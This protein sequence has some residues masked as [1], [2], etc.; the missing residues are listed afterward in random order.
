LSARV[1]LQKQKKLSKCEKVCE[2]LEVASLVR[3]PMG[4]MF[5]NGKHY[6]TTFVGVI[7]SFVVLL[8]LIIFLSGRY[9]HLGDITGVSD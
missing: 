9:N 4:A 8:F 3:K 2:K 6:F 5:F 7:C 1:L